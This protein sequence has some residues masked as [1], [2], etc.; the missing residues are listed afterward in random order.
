ML[1][2]LGPSV[3]QKEHLDQVDLKARLTGIFDQD[4]L[5]RAKVIAIGFMPLFFLIVGALMW[6]KSGM[7]MYAEFCATLV[8]AFVFSLAAAPCLLFLVHMC[9]E[10]DR[11]VQWRASR[12]P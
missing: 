12:R 8:R 6:P 4:F 5:L 1:F 3:A 11:Y 7:T 2:A 9:I 10:A